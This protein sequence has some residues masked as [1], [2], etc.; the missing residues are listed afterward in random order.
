[1]T[2]SG[3]SVLAASTNGASG[4]SIT[5]NGATLTSGANTITALGSGGTSTTGT[6]Q[7]GLNLVSNTTPSVGAARSGT[8][9]ATAIAN[10]GT[11]NTFRFTTGESIASVAGPTNANTFTVSYIANIEGLTEAGVYTSNLT[12]IAT[13]NF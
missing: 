12:Y 9:T 4:Y 11:A 1:V 8:G 2:A 5:V 3:T 7:F 13:A 10:Y 6:E